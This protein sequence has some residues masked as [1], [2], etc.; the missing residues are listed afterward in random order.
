MGV[1]R[2]FAST[3]ISMNMR[4]NIGYQTVS[5][6]I[7]NGP[8]NEASC[9]HAQLQPLCKVHYA[10]PLCKSIMQSPLYM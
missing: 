6:N 5:P 8:G 9:D 10:S 7:L 3:H 1:A 4:A 2:L